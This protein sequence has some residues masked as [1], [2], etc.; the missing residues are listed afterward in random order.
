MEKGKSQFAMKLG[1]VIWSL[2]EWRFHAIGIFLYRSDIENGG[3][4]IFGYHCF[5]DHR[6]KYGAYRKSKQKYFL[7]ANNEL[8]LWKE[9]D[10]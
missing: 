6:T 4:F 5:V 3:D 1:D 10:E 9:E 8:K 2:I 7:F